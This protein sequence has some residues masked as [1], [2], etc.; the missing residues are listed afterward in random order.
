MSADLDGDNA[1]DAREGDRVPGGGAQP[2][3]RCRAR[4]P[5]KSPN[6]AGG[7]QVVGHARDGGQQGDQEALGYHERVTENSAN[8]EVDAAHFHRLTDGN[9]L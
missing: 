9:R 1:G 7:S 8:P 4:L 3:Q 2:R 5:T 6:D